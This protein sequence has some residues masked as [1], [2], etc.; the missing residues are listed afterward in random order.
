MS[1]HSDPQIQDELVKQ[2]ELLPVG[3]LKELDQ[4]DNP[5]EEVELSEVSDTE[6][7]AAAPKANIRKSSREKHLTPK[8]LELMEQQIAQK[9]K[10]FYSAYEKWKAHARDVRA[11]LKN[12]CS[13]HDLCAMMESL[14]KLEAIAKVEY[15]NLRE[16]STPSQEVRRKIDACSAVTRD[17]TQL[18]EVRLSEVG[19]DFD[20]DAEKPRLRLLLD[21]DY[22]KSIYGST[23]S[24]LS[25]TNS[26]KPAS[27]TTSIAAKRTE[28]AAQLAA[29]RV[30]F[31]KENLINAQ[32]QELKRLEHQRD[33]EAMEAK[34]KVYTE[35]ESRGNSQRCSLACSIAMDPCPSS[36]SNRSQG[37]PKNDTS[38]LQALSDSV[39]L[40]RLPVP[41]PGVFSGDPLKFIQWSTSFKALIDR[42][43]PNPADKLF[44]LQRYIAGEARSV[45][46]GNFYRTDK[47]AYQQAWEKLNARYG[48][49]FVIQRAYREKLNGWPRIG[50]K[51]YV[52]LREFGDFLQA[53][54]SAMPHVKGL[55]ILNDCEQNQK[56]L[57]KLPEWVTSRWNRH[58]TEQLDKAE[59][60]PSFKE[61]ASFISKEA[62]IACNPVSSLYAL[63]PVEERST[64]ELKR[65]KANTFATDVQ[66]SDSSSTTA[67]SHINNEAKPKDPKDPTKSKKDITPAQNSGT[68]KCIYCG[69]SHSIH[70]C[71]KLT[72]TSSEEKQKFVRD[73]NLCFACL[74]RGHNSK[75]CQ[76][77]ATCS[78]CKK[79]H[80]TPL[81]EDRPPVE[82][83]PLQR[84][85]NMEGN[86]SALSCSVNGGE[87]GS[88]SM[89][90]PVW[91]SSS[92]TN[93][94]ETLAYALLDTQS[95]K[96]FVDQ[97][98][99]EKLHVAG[100]PVKLKLSTMMGKNST[101]ESQRV[102]GLKVRG[103]S[104]EITIN[105]PPAYSRD[106]IPLERAHIPTCQ[107][108]NMWNHLAAIAHEMPP[109][110]DCGV[111]L[112]IGYD[113]SRALAPRQVIT[114]GDSE[115]Y[116]I[117]T[118]L[119]WSIIGSVPQ[120]VNSKDVTGLCN[121]ISVRELP[122]VTP[123][124]VIRA[125]ES[126]FADTNPGEK[127]ISQEDI[128]FLQILK[129]RIQQNERNHLE[130]PLPFK[131]RPCLPDN[132]RLALVRLRHLE[133]KFERN[134]KFK[135][136][137]VNFMEGVFKDGD[138]EEADSNPVPGN[139]WYIPHQGVY[140]P[141]KPDK[142][143]VVFDCSAKYEGTALNDH[144]LT[145]PDLTNGLIG[146]LCR[147]RKH[148]TAV[149]C[150]VEKMFHRFHVSK[151]DRDYLRFLWWE[152]GDTKCEPKEYRMRVHLFGAASSPGCANY[153]MKYLANQNESEYPLAADFI[154][155]NFYV[156]D[157]IV[158]LE[159]VD[160]AIKLVKE[161]QAVCAKGQLRLHK[162][163]SNDR[164]VLESVCESERAKGVK[165]VD[166]SHEDLPVQTV[167]GVQWNVEKDT[168][169]FKVSLNEKPMTRRGILSTVASVYDPLGFLAPFLLSGKQVLQEMCQKGVGWDELLPDY[170]KPR[171]ESWVNDLKNLEK[172]QIPRCYCPENFGKILRTELHH[173]SDASS[174]GYGQC[175]YIRFVGEDRVHC[176]L[177]IGKARVA[178]T[179][180]VTIPRLE[181]TAAVISAA[182]SSM[183]KEELELRVD[184]EYFWTDS[185]VV[186]GYV[187]NE[188]RRFHVFVAN[189]VQ[190]IRETTNPQQWNYVDTSENPADHA[191]RGLRV[192]ELIISNWFQGPKF[193]WKIELDIKQGTR[194]LL[195]G[196]P[197]VKGAQVLNTLAERQD[198]FLEQLSRFSKWTIAVNVVARIHRLAERSKKTEPLNVEERRQAS[199][200]L[201]KLAQQ[202][203]FKK[204]LLILSKEAGKL[205]HNHPL[206]QL[207]PMLHDGVLRVGGRLRK[208][209]SPFDVRHPIVLPNNGEVTRLILR[210]CHEKT[211]HQGRGQ[212]LNEIR[213]N[214]YWVIG[215]S[216]AVASYIRKC[217]I[218]RKS[219]RPTEQQRMADL[220]TD[221]IE[222]A[223]PFS[224]CGMD[225][226]GPFHT[227]Q[228]RKDQKRYG[229]LFTCLCSRA[230]HIEMLEDMTTDAF[231]NALRCFIA[232]RG[233]VRRI[234]SDH[235]SNFV[236]AKNELEKALKELDGERVAAFLAEQ[237]CDFYMNV[238]DASHV[239]GV[240]ERQIRSVRNVLSS[241]LTQSKGR[242]NDA[243]LRTFF[244][245]AM[246]IINN[247]PLTVDSINNP[248]SLEPLTPNHLLTMKSS[249]P[250]PPPGKFVK[251]DLYVRKRWRRVQYLSEQF[252]CR[253]K[254]EYLAGITLR[255]KW[256]TPSRNVQVDDIVIVQEDA[257]RNEWKLA[258]VLDVCKSDDGL[259]RKATIQIGD[260]RLGKGG[261]RLGKPSVVERPIQKLVV[262]VESS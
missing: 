201:M 229:L 73:N 45:L 175:T 214:G 20:A 77:K 205:S 257:P 220:P 207:D 241:V 245:E 192:S 107:T 147:F 72:A 209:S 132:K 178:P 49:S 212:T 237:Q 208:S 149:M 65:P 64:R 51:E 69:E 150:D 97:E 111:G 227:K 101:I 26:S 159:S 57:A 99:C 117:K 169:S 235:G 59:D 134:P 21:K 254:K 3:L 255:Q 100:E 63:K 22:A 251:E 148:P 224:F 186:L 39:V 124:S 108:A 146:V 83:S 161:A 239:G 46:E 52:K 102:S 250:L 85:Q 27:E 61:F 122:P 34:L 139:V 222:P 58:V 211:Q 12:E 86:T 87:D 75:D 252:W 219:R 152:G 25:V 166:L 225:C 145:G 35:E 119:G 228:G 110:M 54:D 14:E 118:D 244:Y 80:P 91:I 89:I 43:C 158:S 125:L 151:E 256:H 171:W 170:L 88:T 109:L 165:D 242:L 260:R 78:K 29:K 30:E 135:N 127:S 193:L 218:C 44:Y 261:E 116:A 177:I 120:S 70:K 115:P 103:Y 160:R 104:S 197:E 141:R 50:A 243:S 33:L 140:H 137:Y 121:R 142:I 253:W 231:I 48:H 213:A 223:P 185:Q 131:T 210:H 194:E 40:T 16:K 8:M 18:M 233:A 10:K 215:G 258:R 249:I 130:M 71:Q 176:S 98:L 179:K 68:L 41:E 96:T 172:I 23:A 105:L 1:F 53:C 31:E 187:S 56:M 5:Q 156:D 93:G 62:R 163:I 76:K 181:L 230:V 94:S 240:W 11:S 81:H 246:S 153:G 221:R 15:D 173:F 183:L 114:G 28:M 247:R 262:L 190:R 188:A 126:D 55:Q 82:R 195:V 123:A 38:L 138:A 79:S 60:Y 136:D 226:F 180:V 95:S 7:G 154:R 17:L 202:E 129:G 128:Q 36:S 236:G 24:R 196:D 184:K 198:S 133:R 191:S 74:R 47:E 182:V 167:L 143:R 2:S 42:R 199:L 84:A 189:R 259:V 4:T 112:L 106:F 174:Q 92:T 6:Q 204:E 203:A 90:V 162:F 113:C 216:K 238:P 67:R 32:R 164:V 168:F 234:R 37:A 217:V 9:E 144:L 13:D 206:Y 66:T 19:E 232:I 248:T 200:T 155:N 157:G